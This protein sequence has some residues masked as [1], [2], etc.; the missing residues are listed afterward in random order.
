MFKM[1]D[2]KTGDAITAINDKKN[3]LLNKKED[4]LNKKEE[5]K[6][7]LSDLKLKENEARS[8]IK[9]IGTDMK[10]NFI[11]NLG[12]KLPDMQNI[13]KLGNIV[14]NSIGDKIGNIVDK[15]KI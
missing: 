9:N 4:I 3:E 15:V 11:S 1:G 10:D 2:K 6:K 8:A 7:G 13:K 5:I 12:K 14:N